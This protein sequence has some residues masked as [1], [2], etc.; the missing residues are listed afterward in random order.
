M[1]TCVFCKQ[2]RV[3][4]KELS[5]V[6]FACFRKNIQKTSGNNSE[7]VFK[8]S[9]C[10][11]CSNYFVVKSN[12]CFSCDGRFTKYNNFAFG[13]QCLSE[14]CSAIS[15]TNPNVKIYVK[16]YMCECCYKTSTL[17]T[18]DNRSYKACRKCLEDTPNYLRKIAL[19]AGSQ[20][21]TDK[22]TFDQIDQ[23]YLDSPK[24][25]FQNTEDLIY[26]LQKIFGG[27]AFNGERFEVT[28]YQ[29]SLENFLKWYNDVIWQMKI[30]NCVLP[31]DYKKI[32][33]LFSDMKILKKEKDP[34]FVL[35]KMFDLLKT[36]QKN[37]LLSLIE[38]S[39][40][41]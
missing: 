35:K 16:R 26:C 23:R 15:T 27:I 40:K 36:D 30:E 12:T 20:N 2:N 6:F 1:S 29:E 3:E 32:L 31:K 11:Y 10:K 37:L 19:I 38:E 39:K 5:S 25:L 22:N 13:C 17:K 4:K 24:D 9:I 14:R 8:E 41:N 34:K 21:I 28:S 18:G 33:D 7:E